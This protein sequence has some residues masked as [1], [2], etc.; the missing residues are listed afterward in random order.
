MPARFL[1]K[2]RHVQHISNSDSLLYIRP[3]VMKMPLPIRRYDD[4]FLP[5]GKAI[6]QATQDIVCGYIFD[7]AAY[8]AIGAAGAIA[9]ERTLSLISQ[10]NFTVLDGRFA[11][12]EYATITDEIAFMSDALTVDNSADLPF[13]LHRD[14]RSAFVYDEDVAVTSLPVGAGTFNAQALIVHIADN[15][16]HRFRIFGDELIY[17]DSGDDFARYIRAQLLASKTDNT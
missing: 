1:Q 5:F 17:A 12:A 14:D 2:I 6:I 11:G 7:F 4:P 3:V 16:T 9:L 15:Q 10:D 13:Y 8:L